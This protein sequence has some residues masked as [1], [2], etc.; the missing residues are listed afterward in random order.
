MIIINITIQ[1]CGDSV[2]AQVAGLST[3][4]PT[5]EEHKMAAVVYEA[6]KTIA[7]KTGKVIDNTQNKFSQN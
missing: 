5:P 6:L 1:Q 4:Q 7:Y 3:P 2:S